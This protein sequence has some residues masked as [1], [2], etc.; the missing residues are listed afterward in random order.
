MYIDATGTSPFVSTS[1]DLARHQAARTRPRR[2]TSFETPPPAPYAADLLA[3]DG[4]GCHAG[5]RSGPGL[6]VNRRTAVPSA[7]AT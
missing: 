4:S 7:L 1:V 3:R 6:L 2:S 5:S